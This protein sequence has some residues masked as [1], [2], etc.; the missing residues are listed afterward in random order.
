MPSEDDP[1]TE[2]VLLTEGQG[3][4]YFRPVDPE[5]EL[6]KVNLTDRVGKPIPY[7]RGTFNLSE[8]WC[9]FLLPQSVFKIH[10]LYDHVL[11]EILIQN[12]KIHLV[13]TGGRRLLWT[14]LYRT[15]LKQIFGEEIFQNRVH[16]IERVSSENFYNFLALADVILHPFP[17][18]GSR[19]SA[20][21]LMVHKPFITLPTEYLRGRMGYSF[22]RTMNI[23][24]LVATNISNYIQIAGKLANDRNFYEQTVFKI[25]DRLD[26]IWEDMMFPYSVTSFMQRLFGYK[27]SSYEQFL[28]GIKDRIVDVELT[29]TA[30][31]TTNAEAFDEV[32][33]KQLW[34]LDEKG[35]ASLESM[36]DDA[37]RWPRIFEHWRRTDLEQR[38]QPLPQHPDYGKFRNSTLRGFD[39]LQ[40]VLNSMELKK[41][42]KAQKEHVNNVKEKKNV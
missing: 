12:P 28:A 26:L 18:D 30:M 1:Y 19:T 4:W 8:D 22:L 10:P 36:I 9:I 39:L 14:D 41:Q 29:R 35:Q 32:F 34:Q 33:G 21:A 11:S 2:Q 27:V 6:A 16:I 38:G 3:I 17:F 42:K 20:D 5:I 37:S 7:T 25:K 23:P 13:L 15:R 40:Y 31:R 24:E